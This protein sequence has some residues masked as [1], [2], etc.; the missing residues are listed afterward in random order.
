MATAIGVTRETARQPSPGF[1][2]LLC[3]GARARRPDLTTPRTGPASRGRHQ[4]EPFQSGS[5]AASLVRRIGAYGVP[6]EITGGDG[7]VAELAGMASSNGPRKSRPP[8]GPARD[9]ATSAPEAASTSTSA[10]PIAPAPITDTSVICPPPS[11]PARLRADR[12]R[13]ATPTLPRSSQAHVSGATLGAVGLSEKAPSP[14]GLF[15]ERHAC[16]PGASSR[17][18][19]VVRENQGNWY[20]RLVRRPL[21]A[22]SLP[23]TTACTMAITAVSCG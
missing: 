18:A 2:A 19:P 1:S 9:R 10:L 11:G 23:R 21:C 5:I 8:D 15:R 16:R 6:L 12:A 3:R 14:R 7:A 13:P 20:G 17:A 4:Q 22:G